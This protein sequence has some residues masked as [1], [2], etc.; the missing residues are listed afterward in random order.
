VRKVPGK[1]D[2]EYRSHLGSFGITGSTGLQLIGSLSGG[3]KSRVSFALLSLQA[4][5]ILVLDEPTNHMDIEG[6]DALME[7]LQHWN[8]GCIVVSHDTRFINTVCREL[9]V[10]GDQKAD[11]F[12]GD[13]SA[14]KSLIV[15]QHKAKP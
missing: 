10:V 8:G 12:Y 4:P 1:S 6:L 11:K 15:A 9:W 13:V 14:Y 5:H 3:Q 7:A 2:Q